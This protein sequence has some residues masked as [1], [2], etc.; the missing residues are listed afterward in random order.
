MKTL[1]ERLYY[2]IVSKRQERQCAV[3]KDRISKPAGSE[4]TLLI[5]D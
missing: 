2:T 4:R 3:K 1:A 5:N